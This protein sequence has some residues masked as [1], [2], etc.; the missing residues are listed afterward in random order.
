MSYISEIF[1]RVHIQHIR[2]FLLHGVECAN[3]SEKSYK[4]RIED[5][6]K[7]AIEIIQA[8]FPDMDEYE[9]I[10]G[11]V[12]NYVSEVEDVYMEIGLQ[13]GAMLAMQLI[14]NIQ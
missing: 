3:I 5:S 8:K 6:R 4:Q 2:E 14:G 12:D 9:P 13:C 10:I 11:E 1:D 7:T